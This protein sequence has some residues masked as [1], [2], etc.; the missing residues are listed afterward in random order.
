MPPDFIKAAHSLEKPTDK[1]PDTH[2]IYKETTFLLGLQLSYKHFL[3]KKRHI[4]GK[5]LA[6]TR[7]GSRAG[8]WG[9]TIQHWTLERAISVFLM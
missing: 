5:Y 3:L 9:A 6:T 2:F 4:V 1:K 7:G 8:L